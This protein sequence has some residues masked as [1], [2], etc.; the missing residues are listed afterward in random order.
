MRHVSIATVAALA[1]TMS[2]PPVAHA[3][4]G[5]KG[6]GKKLVKY[7]PATALGFKKPK[8]KGRQR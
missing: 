7:D 2:L 6:K 3:G 5:G 4:K 8:G 1:L